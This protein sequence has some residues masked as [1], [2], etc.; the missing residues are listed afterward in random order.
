MRLSA[1][2]LGI[3][4]LWA[5]A[6]NL[7]GCAGTLGRI[8]GGTELPTDLPKE[9]QDR[10]A[11]KDVPVVP[12][13]TLDPT[14]TPMSAPVLVTDAPPKKEKGKKK[15]KGKHGK[16]AEPV[17]QASPEPVVIPDRRPGKDPIW[18]GE[19]ATY[20]ITYFGMEAGLFTLEA[21]PYKQIDGRKVYHVKGTAESSK[22]FN[23]FYRI[24]DSVETFFDF[25]GLY[26]HR[27]HLL[28][29]ESKQ[30]RD[31]L[32][33]NDSM[34]AQTF[35]WNRWKHV[36]K[37]YVETKEF[38]PIPRFPQDSL[39][40]LYYLRTVPLPPDSVVTFP[41]VSEGN[42]WEAV[43]TVVRREMLDTPLGRVQTVVLKPETKYQGIL[44]KRGDSFLWLTDD[45]R[46]HLVRLEA[47]VKIGTVAAELKRLEPGN[48][49]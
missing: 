2:H 12:T 21:L 16:N 23:L 39:S 49:P 32:E 7:V 34:K 25:Q 11:I 27:F 46:R 43:V 15:K 37:E 22:I 38:K 28:L 48:S 17:A 4:F 18:I 47:K 41:V 33:L 9:M 8:G 24:N 20:S 14:P 45:D 35:Y 6:L 10:F 31:A 42:M 13:P 40:A 29:D 1:R 19:K 5:F 44:Q 26:S 30:S 36:E 3:V